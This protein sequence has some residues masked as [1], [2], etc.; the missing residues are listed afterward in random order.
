MGDRASEDPLDGINEIQNLQSELIYMAHK[1]GLA[2][3]N[4]FFVTNNADGHCH[5]LLVLGFC[6]QA[7][8]PSGKYSAEQ[9]VK[10]TVI[11]GQFDFTIGDEESNSK[12]QLVKKSE[13]T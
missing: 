9:W 13:G 2:T 12:G 1:V 5:A 6:Y 8:I 4:G 7:T 3:W 10:P 11:L